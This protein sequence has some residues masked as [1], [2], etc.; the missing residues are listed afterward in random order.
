MYYVIDKSRL[1]DMIDEEVS[2]VADEAYSDTGTAL[3]D[4]IVLTEKDR[5]TIDRFIDDAVSAFV[6][7]EFDV[8]KYAPLAVH[9]DEDPREIS[10]VIPRLLFHV[11][12][13]DETMAA[14]MDSELDRYIVLFSCN[15]LFQQ[16]RPALVPEYTAR[17]QSSMDKAV[18]LLK[19]RKHPVTQW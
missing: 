10:G 13:F 8:T 5:S 15:A 14:T 3:Y 17:T 4:S 6:K 2:K 7:R 1:W 18:A 16:R 9:S 12:D 19:Y 11:P